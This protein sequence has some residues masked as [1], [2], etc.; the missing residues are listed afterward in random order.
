LYA[1]TLASYA[2]AIKIEKSRGLVIHAAIRMNRMNTR[3]GPAPANSSH[4][5]EH[6][7]AQK[8]R[9]LYLGGMGNSS[10]QEAPGASAAAWR[11]AI[12]NPASRAVL[13][14]K[15]RYLPEQ[16][17]GTDSRQAEEAASAWCECTA[18]QLLLIDTRPRI[19]SA[20]G[21]KSQKIGITFPAPGKHQLD[22][23]LRSVFPGERNQL[24]A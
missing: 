22:G 14:E 17:S 21:R 4:F 1:V 18:T 8:Q 24:N 11:S 23:L 15:L 10:N 19:H 7:M 13:Q 3:F 20:F 16:R 5:G 12:V 6:F 9:R 2:G